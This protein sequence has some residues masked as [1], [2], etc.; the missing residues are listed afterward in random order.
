MIIHVILCLGEPQQTIESPRATQETATERKPSF[1]SSQKQTAPIAPSTVSPS[2]P[3]GSRI[4]ILETK[5]NTQAGF[6][7]SG[8]TSAPY[9][10]CSIDENS[11]AFRAGLK[12]NDA[13]LSINEKSVIASS[14]EEVVRLVREAL[15]HKTVKFIVKNRS[16]I[17]GDGKLDTNDQHRMG[18]HLSANTNTNSTT[19]RDSDVSY[20]GGVRSSNGDHDSSYGANPVEEYQSMLNYF[21]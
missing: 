9:L 5:P 14:Y 8:K 7:L 4:C 15:Q 2:L 6:A 3:D 19:A 21:S 1:S 20:Q 13:I 16:A 12:L 17:E 11:P 10:I 18:S